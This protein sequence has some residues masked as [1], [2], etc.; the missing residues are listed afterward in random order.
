MAAFRKSVYAVG[1]VIGV[2]SASSAFL[3][4]SNRPSMGVLGS[5]D[6]SGEK[7]DSFDEPGR[8]P[9]PFVMSGLGRAGMAMEF[10][11]TV[12]RNGCLLWVAGGS[13]SGWLRRRL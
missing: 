10:R 1:G 7:G 2:F 4:A 9:W 3:R 6:G 13:G 8:M 12:G 5:S 11:G